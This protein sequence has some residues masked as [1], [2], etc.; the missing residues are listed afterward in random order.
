MQETFLPRHIDIHV[1]M[2]VEEQSKLAFSLPTSAVE[3][4]QEIKRRPVK[5][6][7]SFTS[8][9]VSVSYAVVLYTS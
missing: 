5:S 8:H 3:R 7:V 4:I 2:E 9:V 1:P 6:R